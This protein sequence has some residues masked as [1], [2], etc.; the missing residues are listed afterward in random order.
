MSWELFNS[1]SLQFTSC[2]ELIDN[3]SKLQGNL[4][5]ST[6]FSLCCLPSEKLKKASLIQ[7]ILGFP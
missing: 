4:G 2:M 7:C 1:E 5:F 6:V 3:I